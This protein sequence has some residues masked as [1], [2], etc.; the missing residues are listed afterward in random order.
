M[1]R[2]A[3][4]SRGPNRTARPSAHRKLIFVAVVA[5]L[6]L[7]PGLALALLRNEVPSHSRLVRTDCVR[8][9]DFCVIKAGGYWHVYAIKDDTTLPDGLTTRIFMHQRSLGNLQAW[10]VFPDD[11]LCNPPRTTTIWDRDHIWAPDIVLRNGLYHMF[12]TG[13]NDS[14]GEGQKIGVKTATTLNTA[15]PTYPSP[16]NPNGTD[17]TTWIAAC[18]D[19]VFGCSQGQFRDPFV[20]RN[21]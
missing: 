3:A 6:A 7:L 4:R 19:T 10:Q 17:P 13:V 11:S 12:Y 8:P 20:M 15:W 9:K 5:A 18:S 1:D 16:W 2:H 21:P 14:V